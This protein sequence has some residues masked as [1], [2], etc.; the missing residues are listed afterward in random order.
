MSLGLVLQEDKGGA[1]LGSWCQEACILVGDTG[2]SHTQASCRWG[3]AIC[4]WAQGDLEG[5]EH[6][7]PISQVEWEKDCS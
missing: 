6:Y 5:R 3:W 2:L 1:D 4:K 7:G